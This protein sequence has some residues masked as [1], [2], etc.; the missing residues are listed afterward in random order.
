MRAPV[1]HVPGEWTDADN[2]S[3]LQSLVDAPD[4]S[5]KLASSGATDYTKVILRES[6]V[7]PAIQ[8]PQTITIDRLKRRTESASGEVPEIGL[9]ECEREP[10]TPGSRTVPFSAGPVQNTY[11]GEVYHIRISTDETPELYKN[12]DQLGLYQMDLRQVITDNLLKDLDN[13]V[14]FRYFQTVRDITGSDVN[15]DGAGGYR[16][17]REVVGGITRNTYRETLRPLQD[18]TLNNGMFVMSRQTALDFL[19]WPREYIGGDLAERLLQDGLNALDKFQLFGVPHVASIKKT[20][21]P[22]GHVFHFAPPNY[23]GRYYEY[24]APTVYVKKERDIIY[25][26]AKRKYGYGIGNEAA[27][28]RT[29]FL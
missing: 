23:L 18:A 6:S 8:P 2:A 16:Q 28:A 5:V 22:L 15:A 7:L 3:L 11:R 25:V 29:V 26:Y 17:Y 24:Q 10:G 4:G 27:V 20:L 13:L 9:V 14:D 21:F 1:V 12:V 19:G